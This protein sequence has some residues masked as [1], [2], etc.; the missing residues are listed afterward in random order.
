MEGEYQDNAE[1]NIE[2]KPILGEVGKIKKG[3]YMIHLLVQTARNLQ[4]ANEDTVDPII[5]AECFGKKKWTSV[6]N[7]IGSNA[8]VS[9]NEHIFFEPKN[10]TSEDILNQKLKIKILDKRMLKNAIIG[11]YEIDLSFIY[12][13]DDHVIL[14]Q[15]VG[16]SNTSSKKFNELSGYLKISVSV[17]GPD[18]NQVALTDDY[19]IEQTDK[20]VLLLP[21][22]ISMKYYQFKFR[23]I[24]AQCLPKMD[25]IG[26]CDAYIKVNYLGKSLKTRTVAQK[27][28]QVTWAQEMWL[29]VQAPLVSGRLVMTVMDYDSTS[30]DDTI[31]SIAF[32]IH[33]L[34]PSLQKSNRPMWMWKDIY[35]APL[36]V[37]GKH[38]DDM[39]KI[40]ET[41]SHW[42]GRVLFQVSCEETD[43]P[44]M[45]VDNIDD[46]VM[47]EANKYLAK[48]TYEIKC[49]ISQGI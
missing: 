13:K 17:I 3:D 7:D 45:K 43:S 34:L 38:T 18:D 1:D 37:S 11:N 35:G 30:S 40:P 12:F 14:N 42:K 25:T 9:W 39:N 46:E 28:N 20:E 47:M 21:P 32:Q 41:A 49:E 24:K 31:G 36:N 48:K 15:W 29:P 6:K 26:D 27:N 4:I 5:Q 23:I 22:H 19:G 10:L 2:A 33:K 16:L 44:K 8:S